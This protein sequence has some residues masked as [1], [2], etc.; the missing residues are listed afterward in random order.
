MQFIKVKLQV[1]FNYNNLWF[2]CRPSKT[3]VK[4]G[5]SVRAHFDTLFVLGGPLASEFVSLNSRVLTTPQ[6]ID[7]VPGLSLIQKIITP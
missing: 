7:T 4:T 3:I 2:K 6:K 5:A 1:R